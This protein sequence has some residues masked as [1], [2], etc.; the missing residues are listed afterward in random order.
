LEK[1]MR[2]TVLVSSR[3]AYSWLL[4][5]EHG[6][7]SPSRPCCQRSAPELHAPPL[8]NVHRICPVAAF[9]QHVPLGISVQA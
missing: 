5:T 9:G 3:Q 6:I 4:G 8:G 1:L 7:R 2:L